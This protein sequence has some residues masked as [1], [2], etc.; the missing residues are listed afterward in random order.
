[1]GNV[2]ADSIDVSDYY[3]AFIATESENWWR[4][5]TRKGFGHCYVF[6][7]IGEMTQSVDYLNGNIEITFIDL[8]ADIYAF[9]LIRR[10][11]AKV[12]K[13]KNVISKKQGFRGL[14]YCVSLCKAVLGIRNCFAITP[15]KLYCWLK[16]SSIDIIDINDLDKNLEEASNG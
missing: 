11:D 2:R 12:L 8:K 5:F 3:I 4:F 14:L 13:I 6:T 15:Y 16:S 1:M 7:G 9:H 10:H